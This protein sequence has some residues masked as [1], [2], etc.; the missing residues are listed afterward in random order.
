LNGWGDYLDGGL[1]RLSPMT[2]KSARQSLRRPRPR[3]PP[4]KRD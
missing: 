4:T 3:P 2:T 1:E